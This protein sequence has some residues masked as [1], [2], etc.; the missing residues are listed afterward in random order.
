MQR[1]RA[2]KKATKRSER[3]TEAHRAWDA[4]IERKSQPKEAAQANL[5]ALRDSLW[6]ESIKL[7]SV[8]KLKAEI[9]VIPDRLACTDVQSER[10]ALREIAKWMTAR[11]DEMRCGLDKYRIAVAARWFAARG[12]WPCSQTEAAD[13][14]LA[15]G[16]LTLDMDEP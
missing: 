15:T 12:A 14:G 8:R 6:A 7:C 1:E 4:E 13:W 5:R 3:M 2:A 10:D 9:N 16:G 11:R